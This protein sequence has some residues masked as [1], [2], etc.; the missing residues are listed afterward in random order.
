MLWR[1]RRK[2]Y[3]DF[4]AV[5]GID[6]DIYRGETVGI[7]GRNGSGKSTLLKLICGTLLPTDGQLEVIGHVAP[8]LMLGAG[9]NPDFTGRE[10]V[11]LNS[12]ILGLSE[13]EIHERLDSIIAFADIG[14]FFDQPVKSYSSGMH[15]RLSFAVA[16]NADPDILVIDEVLAVGDEAFNRKCFARIEEI[17]AHGATILFVSHNAGT[18]LEFCDRAVLMDGGERLLTADPKTVISRYQRLLYAPLDQRAKILDEIRELDTGSKTGSES[19]PSETKPNQK[20][21]IDGTL[22]YGYFDPNLKSQSTVEYVQMGAFIHSVRISDPDGNRVN[23]LRPDMNYIYEYQVDFTEPAFGVRFGMM[24]K[25][26]TGFEIAGQ[27]S[28]PSRTGFEFIEA[29]TTARVRMPF[30]TA[31]V[32]GTYFLNAGVRGFR[33]GNEVYLHR[34]L[35]VEMFRIAPDSQSRVT[36]CV[37]L[38]PEVAPAAQIEFLGGD[39][40]KD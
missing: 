25:L 2:F 16:I 29:G 13:Q 10:N 35:D 1:G 28:H 4:L 20:A 34:I 37:N 11:F 33:E 36:G 3:Q 14:D 23:M 12:T 38:A 24:I 9:F 18:I 15:S 26:V 39:S 21:Q 31:L 40:G 6:L 32:P 17:K 8:L 27:T 30:R 7:V 5:H 19:D 22:D